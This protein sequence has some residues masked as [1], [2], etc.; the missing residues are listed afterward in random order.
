MKKT[1]KATLRPLSPVLRAAVIHPLR[2]Y[3]R[4]AGCRI[5]KRTLWNHVISHLWWAESY[6][7]ATTSFGSSLLANAGDIGGR[8]IY[9][10]GT[11]EPNLTH[12]MCERLRPGDV[13]VDVGANI[14][15]FSLLASKL[16]GRDGRVVAIEALPA[17][18]SVLQQNIAANDSRNVRAVNVAAWDSETTLTMFANSEPTGTSTLVPDWAHRWNLNREYRVSAKPMA[19]IL[20]GDEIERA[21]LIKIDVEGAEWNVVSGM[22][23][24]LQRSSPDLEIMLEVAPS[25][26]GT[27]CQD[28]VEVLQREGFNMYSIVNDY[29]ATS[30]FDGRACS[31][32]MRIDR[33]PADR[34]QTDVVF[35]KLDAASL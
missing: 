21:R 5:G 32:P 4:Y 18:F 19:S 27:K 30:Y 10:F 16:V 11:W 6:V 13:F 3:F 22:K 25:I 2:A 20:S 24:F 26:L 31:R 14:G 17:T 23:Q 15:Y 12:W 9:Y 29:S 8:Y 28:I 35:S 1:L 33:I 7:N 34:E